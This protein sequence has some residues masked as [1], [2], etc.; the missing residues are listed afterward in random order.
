MDKRLTIKEL[1]KMD[2]PYEK[3]EQ[4][5]SNI[6][7]DAELL[8]III[9]TGSKNQTSVDLARKILYNEGLDYIKKATFEQLVKIKGVGRVKALQIIALRELNIRMSTFCLNDISSYASSPTDVSNYLMERMRFL[10]KEIFKLLIL[11]SKN[12][13]LKEKDISIGSLDQTIV[14]PR[15]IFYEAIRYMAKSVILVHNHPSGDPTPS[16]NDIKTT[17]RLIKGGELLGIKV[18]DHIIIG[19][20]VTY[21]FKNSGL[22]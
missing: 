21:S 4:L 22:I 8:A 11:D 12:K 9:K 15:E 7:S 18:L 14:H 13:I 19:N 1:P 5:G 17:E 16:K 10:K 2:R 20:G 3:L 6:L